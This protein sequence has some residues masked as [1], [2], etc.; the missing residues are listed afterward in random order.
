MRT[1]LQT[2][3]GAIRAAESLLHGT[4]DVVLILIVTFYLLLD[5]GRF[6]ETALRFLHPADRAELTRVA[7]RIHVVVGRWLRGQL[8]LV[9]LVGT[10]VTVVFGFVLHLPYPLA[11]GALV[12]LLG[13]ITFIGPI[14]AGTIVA[15]VALASGGLPLAVASVL[16]L[17]VLRQ[18]ENVLIMPAV[19]GR[20]VDLH[21]LVALF[22]VVVASTAFGVAGTFLAIPVAAG[23]NVALREFFPEEFGRVPAPDGG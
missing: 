14:V 6:S 18:L 16:F 17:T 15:I 20:A 2:P 12:A 21:P 5:G 23:I 22:A 13:V 8:L 11:L 19:L 9:A 7:G 10:V 4:L 3:E 1:F